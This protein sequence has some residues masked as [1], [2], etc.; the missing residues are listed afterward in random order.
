MSMTPRT[1]GHRY[2]RSNAGR[3][4]WALWEHDGT[5]YRRV[6]TARNVED[7]IRFLFHGHP[8]AAIKRLVALETRYPQ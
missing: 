3:T 4:T 7:Y 2:V 8:E 5:R 6:G 1:L